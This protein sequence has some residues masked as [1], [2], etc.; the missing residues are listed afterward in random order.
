MPLL[1]LFIGLTVVAGLLM[2]RMTF[3]TG[4]RVK[5]RDIRPHHTSRPIRERPGPDLSQMLD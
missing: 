4:Y 3:Q 1:L 2:W 5:N